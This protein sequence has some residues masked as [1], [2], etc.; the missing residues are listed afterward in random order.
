MHPQRTGSEGGRDEPSTASHLGHTSGASHGQTG[1]YEAPRPPLVPTYDEMH[2]AQHFSDSIKPTK[3]VDEPPA[4]IIRQQS[5]KLNEVSY[6]FA[7]FGSI[8]PRLLQMADSGEG[9]TLEDLEVWFETEHEDLLAL[10]K[11][12]ESK[13]KL[14]HTDEQTGGSLLSN[15]M[16]VV[17]SAVQWCIDMPCQ[18]YRWLFNS[19]DTCRLSLGPLLMQT[20]NGMR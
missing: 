17:S 1:G 18:K 16:S 15:G 4:T 13:W 3:H 10:K 5:L 11:Q 19:H 12:F 6:V 7:R 8:W 14:R 9:P 2:L 20:F